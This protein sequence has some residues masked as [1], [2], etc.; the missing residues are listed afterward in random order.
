MTYTN[1]AN[2]SRTGDLYDDV[3]LRYCADDNTYTQVPVQRRAWACSLEDAPYRSPF[4]P[5]AEV[6]LFREMFGVPATA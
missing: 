4:T 1:F 2:G 6:D 5:L 3:S